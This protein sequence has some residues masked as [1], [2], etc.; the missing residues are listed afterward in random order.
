[1]NSSASGTAGPGGSSTNT[2]AQQTNVGGTVAGGVIS[3]SPW[4]RGSSSGT[5][6]GSENS[7]VSGTA[8]ATAS[9]TNVGGF[10]AGTSTH[11]GGGGRPD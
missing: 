2:S 3:N 5:A 6:G 9:D 1:V 4:G 7:Q 11:H 10:V 8:G